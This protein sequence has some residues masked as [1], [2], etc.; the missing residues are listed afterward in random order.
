MGT[1]L[2]ELANQLFGGCGNEIPMYSC[3]AVYETVAIFLVMHSQEYANMYMGY[4][5]AMFGEFGMVVPCTTS[6]SDL[7]AMYAR[8][9]CTITALIL[10]VVFNM[11][12]PG[13]RSA[14]KAGIC[15]VAA[16]A[17]MLA[18]FQKVFD[19]KVTTLLLDRAHVADQTATAVTYGVEAGKDPRFWRT[20]WKNAAFTKAVSCAFTIRFTLTILEQTAIGH[21]GSEGPKTAFFA[22]MIK[23]PSFQVF[24]DLMQSRMCLLSDQ[25]VYIFE[26]EEADTNQ[27]ILDRHFALEDDLPHW[28][29]ARIQF[30]AS[31]NSLIESQNTVA[32][33]SLEDDASSQA[34]M[35]LTAID[36]TMRELSKVEDAFLQA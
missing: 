11:L 3:L 31:V 34:C 20:P 5:I 17:N 15:I 21:V 18:S 26:Y 12:I 14:S 16:W 9:S 25:G 32:V 33:T 13:E 10:I 6:T 27:E 23:L 8:V 4:M 19:P 7:A 28:D 24:W 1:V 36:M 22:S 2:G 30:I 29:D 35:V